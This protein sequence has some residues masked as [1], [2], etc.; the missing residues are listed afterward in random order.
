MALLAWI[1]SPRLGPSNFGGG[2][3]VPG[4][5]EATST[6]PYST[7][8][9]LSVCPTISERPSPDSRWRMAWCPPAL[10]QS[11]VAAR[12]RCSIV[13][14]GGFAESPT[15]LQ[16]AARPEEHKHPR[17]RKSE[18]HTRASAFS[19]F[20]REG[21]A[22]EQRRAQLM[23]GSASWPLNTSRVLFQL[24]STWNAVQKRGDRCDSV[25]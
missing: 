8:I 19:R 24:P 23:H 3:R 14:L 25:N 2:W 4:S 22:A 17:F 21:V 5:W 11:L 12:S 6:D 9:G 20:F 10:R 16:L 18:N 13:H 1:T 7:V 15:R